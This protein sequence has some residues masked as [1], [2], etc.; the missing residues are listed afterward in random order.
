MELARRHLIIT[1]CLLLLSCLLHAAVAFAPPTTLPH[2][3]ATKIGCSTPP[4]RASRLTASEEEAKSPFAGFF[5]AAASALEGLLDMRYPGQLALIE[6]VEKKLRATPAVIEALG[7]DVTVGYVDPVE[8]MS[9]E[10]GLQLQCKC[11]GSAGSGTLWVRADRDVDDSSAPLTL[12]M[13]LL[14]VGE[15]YVEVDIE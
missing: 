1:M 10:A 4:R 3:A 14:K 2:A 7:D 15:E 6:V 8:S 12:E 9:S 11:G 5:K 13:L